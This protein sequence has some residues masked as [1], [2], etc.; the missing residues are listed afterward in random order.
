MNSKKIRKALKHVSP[1][2]AEQIGKIWGAP[3][4]EDVWKRINEKM[5]FEEESFMKENTNITQ[6][7]NKKWTGYLSIA[8]AIALFCGAVG[9]GIAYIKQS[10]RANLATA[11]HTSPPSEFSPAESVYSA[12]EETFPTEPETIPML[13]MGLE[14]VTETTTAVIETTAPETAVTTVAED[15]TCN[16]SVN[17][18]M[19]A[20]NLQMG[21]DARKARCAALTGE[22]VCKTIELLNIQYGYEE[23]APAVEE[24]PAAELAANEYIG[25]SSTSRGEVKVKVTMDGDKIAK[26]EVL[27]SSE[28][29]GICDPAMN[30]IPQAIIDAQSTEVDAVTNATETSKAIMAAV[31]DALSQIKK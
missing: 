9:G 7:K 11:E 15:I 19:K 2:D 17:K 28:T 26:I 29:P 30:T 31:E 18:F 16:S 13:A 1:E 22:V 14:T 12:K 25:T 8:A 3:H 20:N 27:S 10:G 24:A 4:K 23:A 6:S 5:N 21:D